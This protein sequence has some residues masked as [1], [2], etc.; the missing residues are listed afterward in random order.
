[1]AQPNFIDP[2]DDGRAMEDVRLGAHNTPRVYPWKSLL[3]AGATLA[4]SS[5]YYVAPGPALLDVYA[6]HTR[7]NR[8]GQPAGGW[9]P[10]ERLSPRQAVE[11]ATTLHRGGGT[12]RAGVLRAGAVADLTVL[13]ANPLTCPPDELLAITVQRTVRRGTATYT[14]PPV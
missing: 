1:M 11:L 8:A 6:A 2:G 7:A 10:Q 5:D 14:A 9:Q 13:S 12:Q 4:L 3:E